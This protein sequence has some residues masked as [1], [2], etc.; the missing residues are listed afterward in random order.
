[1]SEILIELQ[2]SLLAEKKVAYFN[3]DRSELQVRCPY[4]GDSIK[5]KTHAHLY[6]SMQKPHSFYCQKCSSSGVLTSQFLED[7]SIDN[8][9]LSATIHREYKAFRRDT[10][11]RDGNR[12]VLKLTKVKFPK[13]DI[14]GD[15]DKKLH[16]IEKRL[17]YELTRADLRR[18]RVLNSLSD[19]LVI[20]DMEHLLQDERFRKDVW[21]VDKFAV[22]WL[23][24]DN[25]YASFRFIEGDFKKRF[26][27]IGFDK[28]GEGSKIFTIKSQIEMMAKDIEIVMCEGFFDIVSVYQNFYREK[29]NLNRIFSAI[30]GKGFN[31]F[32]TTLMRMG[33]MN[34]NLVIYSDNDVSME[35]YRYVLNLY[36]YKSVKVVYNKSE[37]QKDFGVRPELIKPKR[38]TLK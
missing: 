23:S 26:K 37:G 22:G 15:F 19:F 6:V 2:Q 38:Y 4:C 12:T 29:D 14:G 13:Y 8:G 21:L 5:D 25:T 27:T 16:Y 3:S 20:N 10:T 7:M 32:P 11:V 35:D 17:G 33:Y 31:L 30:N 34:V 1:M 9:E 28:F 18:F 36:K 24:Q